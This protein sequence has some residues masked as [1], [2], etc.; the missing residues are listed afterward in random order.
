MDRLSPFGQAKR[1]I[2]GNE[3]GMCLLYRLQYI[4]IAERDMRVRPQATKETQARRTAR[5][6]REIDP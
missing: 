4:F 3:I 5:R 1:S 2:D 6:T